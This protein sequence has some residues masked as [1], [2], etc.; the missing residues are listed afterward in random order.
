LRSRAE[1]SIRRARD[2]LDYHPL[3]PYEEA[4]KRIASYLEG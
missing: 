1:V 4:M 2:D 3:V